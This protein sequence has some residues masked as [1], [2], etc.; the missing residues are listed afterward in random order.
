MPTCIISTE[1]RAAKEAMVPSSKDRQRVEI[2]TSLYDRL[3]L[4]ADSEERTVTSLLQDLL[5]LGLI[6][7]QPVWMPS[8]FLNRFTEGAQRA[9]SLA[10]E[11]AQGLHHDYIGTEH[12]LLGLLRE[13]EGIAAEV[14]HQLWIDADQVRKALVYILTHHM[15]NQP[16]PGSGAP[17]VKRGATPASTPAGSANASPPPGEPTTFPDAGLTLRART[18][19]SLAVD[20]AQRLHQDYVGT[21]HLLLALAREGEGLAAGILR[22]F[23]ALSKVHEFTM[24]RLEQRDAEA[25]HTQPAS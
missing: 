4:L 19:L 20:E 15:P 1:N 17:A 25:P 14:L 12:L 13:D 7:Y 22:T 6:H 23:G 18:V 16:S 2:P 11:E 9:L 10:R 24:A 3:K 5:R 21:E 8:R